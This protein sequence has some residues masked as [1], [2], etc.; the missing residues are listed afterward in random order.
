ML[1]LFP[2]LTPRRDLSAHSG[3]GAA[4]EGQ[5]PVLLLL[6]VGTADVR[7]QTGPHRLRARRRHQP[8]RR[9]PEHEPQGH[10]G[11]L[12]HHAAGAFRSSTGSTPTHR[13][14]R[15]S[16]AINP[17]VSEH[18]LPRCGRRHQDEHLR[19]FPNQRRED[20]AGRQRAVPRHHPHPSTAALQTRLL[21]P[22]RHRLHPHGQSLLTHALTPTRT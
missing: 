6:L 16:T 14:D 7:A 2:V 17:S 5:V 22:H 4:A 3:D 21:Q 13:A 11:V 1:T 12:R 19:H 9:D 8:G 15:F 18:P 20:Q 10:H